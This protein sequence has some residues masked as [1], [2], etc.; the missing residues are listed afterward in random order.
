MARLA[1]EANGRRWE[2]EWL[3]TV[4]GNEQHKADVRNAVEL[5]IRDYVATPLSDRMPRKGFI[6]LVNRTHGTSLTMHSLKHFIQRH[7]AGKGAT[8]LGTYAKP[9]VTVE[10]PPASAVVSPAPVYDVGHEAQERD[11]AAENGDLRRANQRLF[12]QMQRYKN[13]TEDLV[14]ATIDGARDAMLSMGPLGPVRCGLQDKREHGDEVALW[15]MSDWQGA[16]LTTSYNSQVMRERV[17]RFCEKAQKITNIQRADHPVRECVIAFGG[18]MVEGLF[19]FPTQPFEIDQTIFGQYVTVSR[20]LIEVVQYAL[21]TYERVRVVAEWGNHGRMGSKR[22]A[23][24]KSDNID[25]MCY[26]LARQLLAGESRLTWEDCPEDIQRIEIGAY[27]AL[28]IHGDEVGRM[29]YASPGTILQWANRQRSGAYG[30]DFRD[31]YIGHYHH[32]AEQALA[33]GQGMLFHTGSTESDNRYARDN[34]AASAIPS[35]RLHFIDPER[36]RVSAQ[37]KIFL[38]KE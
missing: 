30:W 28:L 34:L 33:N 32:H 29:G 25:R 5:M 38:D 16:K 31:V 17:L 26:E 15:H 3:Q 35:Q 20:L 7:I 37:Y 4:D 6:E 1:R 10:E 14:R 12:A 36:G 22:D 11:Y 8:R 9:S 19:N 23:V 24:P 2:A 27:K 18:D 13:Q 21:R